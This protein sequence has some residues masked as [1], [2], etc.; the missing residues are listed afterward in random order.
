MVSDRRDGPYRLRRLRQRLSE[1][2]ERGGSAAV[3]ADGSASDVRSGARPDSVRESPV[4]RFPASPSA[5]GPPSGWSYRGDR[6]VFDEAIS[7]R[8]AAPDH[9]G[10]LDW[11][12][13]PTELARSDAL[14]FDLETTGL[15]GGDMIFMAGYLH[16]QG[17]EL[18]LVQE[19]ARDRA[20]EGALVEAAR[21]RLA[22]HSVLVTFNGKSFDVPALERRLFYH[23][24]PALDRRRFR[25]VDLL[26]L[27]RR[28]HR[29]EFVDCRLGTLERELL[30]KPRRAEDLPS[31]EVPL[32]FED[33]CGTSDWSHLAPVLYHNRIDLATL[34]ALWPLLDASEPELDLG[35]DLDGDASD[36]SAAPDPRRLASRRL[37]SDP[38]AIDASSPDRVT[39]Q[40]RVDASAD[41]SEHPRLRSLFSEG[42]REVCRRFRRRS[43]RS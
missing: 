42:A 37:D 22:R 12:R 20:E 29:R 4:A 10:E 8:T 31:A 6:F 11:D 34:V 19:V 1:L 23:R 43:G 7:P 40:S 28:R 39:P 30:S 33:Y 9:F 15:A 21:E 16:W 18:R 24:A 2:E 17:D 14:F 32:R 5:P 25:I 36:G 26:H 38:E 27:A 13:Y 35:W 3:G 41:G